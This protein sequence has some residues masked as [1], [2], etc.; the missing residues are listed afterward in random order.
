MNEDL[1]NRFAVLYRIRTLSC[2]SSLLRFSGMSSLSTTPART[3]GSGNPPTIFI[4]NNKNNP[5]RD[6]SKP[7]RKRSHLGRMS[8]ALVW[9]RTFRLYSAT[10]E[11]NSLLTSNILGFC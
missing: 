4:K 9:I 11:P 6:T 3:D 7:L 1:K 8:V 10:L 5:L 2:S